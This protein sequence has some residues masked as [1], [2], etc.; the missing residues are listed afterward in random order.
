M[1]YVIWLLVGALV[2]L[3]LY[4]MIVTPAGPLQSLP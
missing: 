4:L 1:K 2:L 3:I